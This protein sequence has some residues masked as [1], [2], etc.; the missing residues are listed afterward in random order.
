MLLQQNG[1]ECEYEMNV[2]M[3]LFFDASDDVYVYTN[4]TYEGDIIDAY[5]EIICNGDTYF[6]EF[7][8]NKPKTGIEKTDNK[9]S[10]VCCTRAFINAAQKITKISLPWGAMC[11]VRPAK[12]VT[13]LVED[14]MSYADAHKH[15]KEAYGVTDEKCKLACKVSQN[16][17]KI[18]DGI[19]DNSVSIYIGIP[20][21]PSRC[22]YCS[23]VSTDIGTT[24]KYID[25]FVE[26]LL[27][28]IEIT[29]QMLAECGKV[30][31]NIY[32]GGGTPTT[33]NEN[34]LERLLSK[35]NECFDLSNMNEFTLEAGRPDTITR[36]KLEIAKRY[37]VGRVSINPQTT[38][39]KTL[40]KIGR[41]HCVG[42]FFDAYSLAR[43]VGFDVINTDL[44]AGLPDEDFDDFKKS[45]DNL[46]SLSPENITVHSMSIKRAAALRHKISRL[47]EAECMN[48]MLSYAQE[49][50]EN[51]GYTPYYMYRQK[52]I[53]GNLENVGYAKDGTFSFY[54]VNIMEEAQ[55]II[56]LGGGGTS[57]IVTDDGIERIFNFKD[58]IEYIRK[59]DE[60]VKRKNDIKYLLKGGT[61]NADGK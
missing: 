56:A 43:D 53:S 35:I 13:K 34:Q 37:N 1:F 8:L 61:L 14:G 30:I 58:P 29:A 57:K 11:G 32:I 9:Y 48:K 36:E 33:L 50:L 47:T 28:E 54:N 23:F 17:R 45:I 6:G 51:N 25:E 40:A 55:T 20:F 42:E 49:T 39:N 44:I 22:L 24:G 27:K 52:N 16:E 18:L 2:F 10:S 12:A 3:R 21:C 19:R 4:L 7:T 5:C 59:F 26:N 60:I 38:N 15:L 46:V 41:R 31:E